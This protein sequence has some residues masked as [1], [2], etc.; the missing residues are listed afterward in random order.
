MKLPLHTDDLVCPDVTAAEVSGNT[1]T[2]FNEKGTSCELCNQHELSYNDFLKLKCERCHG[3]HAESGPP[4]GSPSRQMNHVTQKTST[5]FA[6]TPPLH[7]TSANPPA[8]QVETAPFPY[9]QGVEKG[10]LDSQ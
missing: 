8:R 1:E 3:G 5:F 4:K 2:T 10:A 9:T 7:R 6:V